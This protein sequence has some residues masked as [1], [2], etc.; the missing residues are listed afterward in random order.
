VG[1]CL[2]SYTLAVAFGKKENRMQKKEAGFSK[3]ENARPLLNAVPV[4][5]RKLMGHRFGLRFSSFAS[6]L[7]HGNSAMARASY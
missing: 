1:P 2:D 5:P 3:L 7:A 4:L 6:Q